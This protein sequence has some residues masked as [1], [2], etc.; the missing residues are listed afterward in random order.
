MD[1][2]DASLIINPRT[3]QNVTQIPD[4]L[5]VLAAAGWDTDVLL[6]EY[7]GHAMDLAQQA[8]EDGNDLLIAY[9]GD[10]TLNQVVNGVMHSKKPKKKIVGVIPGGTANLWAGD[11]GVP[12]DPVQAALSLINSQPHKI[13]VGRASVVDVAFPYGSTLAKQEQSKTSAKNG[14]K[15][16]SKKNNTGVRDHFLL[17]AG[18]GFDAAV[19]ND[20]SKQLKYHI[21]PLAVG[22][23]VARNLPK[24]QPFPL[25]IFSVEDNGEHKLL[26]KGDAQQV[27]I[28]NTRRYAVILETTPNAYIDDGLLDVCIITG[29]NAL[30]TMQQVTELLLRRKPESKETVCLQGAHLLMKV[31]ASVPFQVDGSSVKIKDF[32]SKDYADQLKFV[33]KPEEVTITYRFDALEHALNVAFPQTYDGT[34]FKKYDH[35]H[36]KAEQTVI[37]RLREDDKG[38]ET[39]L[40]RETAA[41]ETEPKHPE[42]PELADAVQEKQKT[43]NKKQK[44]IEGTVEPD[45]TTPLEDMPGQVQALKDNGREIQV[46]GH[47]LDPEH[48]HTYIVA[49]QI[50]KATTGDTKPVAVVINAATKILTDDGAPLKLEAI[51][52]LNK[53][54]KIVVEGKRSKR[55]VIHAQRVVCPAL[56]AATR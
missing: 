4:V 46:V 21:G 47:V 16:V 13:D 52:N 1:C 23:S 5:A 2:K 34:L 11:T 35:E 33:E 6:K 17:M 24:N 49:G 28:G 3:G 30:S 38:K 9:G 50:Q 18:L 14:H 8:S 53:G 43:E 12:I 44:S 22:L 26:W 45:E 56:V 48:S 40:Q 19:M 10:G 55:G 41:S 37:E 25:E 36:G 54:E 31:P 32:L 7:G 51:A 39:T 15:K 42:H 20:V 27:I 29:E